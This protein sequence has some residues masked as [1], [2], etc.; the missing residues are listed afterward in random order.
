MFFFLRMDQ[1]DLC[2]FKIQLIQLVSSIRKKKINWNGW[3]R[4]LGENT[5]TRKKCVLLLVSSFQSA[6]NPSN[7]WWWCLQLWS[8]KPLEGIRAEET[9]L[10]CLVDCPPPDFEV[11]ELMLNGDI[12]AGWLQ[13]VG[14]W[15]QELAVHHCRDYSSM[16]P[17]YLHLLH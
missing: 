8:N 2:K 14:S 5:N 10:T 11:L 4:L 1:H 17:V 12:P 3:W 13:M 9:C 7:M 16:R 15:L 6:V